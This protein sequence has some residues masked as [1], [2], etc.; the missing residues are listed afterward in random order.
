[1]KK[2]N[3]LQKALSKPAALKFREVCRL[4]EAYG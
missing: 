1:M 4:A 3:L 2:R